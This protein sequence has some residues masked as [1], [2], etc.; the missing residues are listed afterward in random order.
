MNN[1]LDET[2]IIPVSSKKI[3]HISKY[4][5]AHFYLLMRFFVLRNMDNFS[6]ETHISR[7]RS[8]SAAI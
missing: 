4:E 8:H 5:K 6:D 2:G 1:F 7:D 3:I